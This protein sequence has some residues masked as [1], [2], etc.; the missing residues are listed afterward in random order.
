MNEKE[1]CISVRRAHGH[2]ARAKPRKISA[3]ERE[4]HLLV[5]QKGEE[6][7]DLKEI[8]KFR[9]RMKNRKIFQ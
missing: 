8:N 4:N 6:Q 7:K 5:H 9:V 3:S 2:R 1:S